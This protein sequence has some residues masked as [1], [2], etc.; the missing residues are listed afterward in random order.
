MRK[1]AGLAAQTLASPIIRDQG[2]KGGKAMRAVQGT[3]KSW[4][5]DYD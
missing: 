5:M 3:K 4:T 2:D 1:E